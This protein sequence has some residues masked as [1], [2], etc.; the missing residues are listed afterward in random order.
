MTA[1][2]LLQL[3]LGGLLGLAGQALRLVVGLKKMNDE[4]VR[5]GTSV[6]DLLVT[7][8]M[9]TSLL[10]GF[11]AGLLCILSLSSFKPD[12]LT[13]ADA[14]QVI[15]SI[16]A[17]GYAGTDF[18]EGFIQKFLGGPAQAPAATPATSPADAYQQSAPNPV[19]PPVAVPPQGAIY[20]P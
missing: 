6:K 12:F 16:V 7:S 9:V 5:S 18:I 10:I 17:A 4:A 13:G 2:I 15:L 3:L 14:K 8:R 1:E 11:V 19:I 20:H